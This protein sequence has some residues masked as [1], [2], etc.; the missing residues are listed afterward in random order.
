MKPVNSNLGQTLKSKKI[1][2]V[3]TGFYLFASL[4]PSL[5]NIVLLPIYSFYVKPNEY[6]YLGLALTF[7]NAISLFFGYQLQVGLGRYYYDLSLND[8][9]SLLS[10]TFL[11]LLLINSP[12]FILIHTNIELLVDF[13]FPH[14]PSDHFSLFHPALVHGAIVILNSVL[15]TVLRIQQKAKQYMTISIISTLINVCIGI[16]TVI[17]KGLGAYGLIYGQVAAAASSVLMAVVIL[18]NLIVLRFDLKLFKPCFKYSLPLNPQSF[19]NY[20]FMYSD[21]I[22]LEKFISG[23][24]LGVYFMADRI[25][26][27]VKTIVTQFNAAFQPQFNELSSKQGRSPAIAY[28]TSVAKVFLVI[29]GTG[30]IIFAIFSKELIST[31]LSNRYLNVWRYLPLLCVPYLFRALYTFCLSALLYDKRT[32]LIATISFIAGLISLSLNI[33]LIPYFGVYAA[34]I[35]ITFSYFLIFV[36]AHKLSKPSSFI[37]L[38]NHFNFRLV[39]ITYLSIGLSFIFN[40]WYFKYNIALKFMSLMIFILIIIKVSSIHEFKKVI[41]NFFVNT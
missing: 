31:F 23:D 4:L 5:I 2:M 3:N 40:E 13:I 36:L 41:A 6:G 11:F 10:T 1:L 21:K 8:F 25:S 29:L 15:L 33:T 24:A 20:L 17:F 32:K 34:I 39:I 7:S 19:F 16:Y 22:I 28:T 14:M 18:K 12:I 35:S 26:T 9:K 30:I 38:D 37:P 27:L